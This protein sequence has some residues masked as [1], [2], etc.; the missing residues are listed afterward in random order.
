MK[1]IPVLLLVFA[2]FFPSCNRKAEITVLKEGTP[3]FKLARDLAV[4]IPMLDPV[5]N[6]VLVRTRKFDIT[7]G[8]AIQV[9]LGNFGNQTEQLKEFDSIQLRESIETA[10]VELAEKKLLLQEAEKAKVFVDPAVMDE[11][12]KAEHERLGGKEKFLE[13]LKTIEVDVETIMKSLAEQVRID[14]FLEKT[15]NKNVTVTAEEVA[16]TYGEDMTA[17]VRHILLLTQGKPGS[18]KTKIRKRMAGILARAR[19]GEDFAEL[20][21]QYSEEPGSKESGGMYAVLRGITD[22]TFEDAAFSV[23]IGQISDIVE[24]TYGYHILQIISREKETRPFDEV[25][26][27]IENR[28]AG[29]KRKVILDAFLTKIKDK[30]GFKTV[31]F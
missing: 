5:E 24:T 31:D 23:P 25:K 17:S 2:F 15:L 29:R 4:K 27:E 1:R 14:A 8:E 21:K 16:R 18:E 28:I 3:A 22:K 12:I 19:S 9:L 11:I 20:A 7:T 13:S 6:N 26:G 30:A 10:A